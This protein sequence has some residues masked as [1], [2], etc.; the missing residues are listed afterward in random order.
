MTE[1]GGNMFEKISGSQSKL[2]EGPPLCETHV[3]IKEMTPW[4]QEI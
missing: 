3:C 2:G 1:Y 4:V